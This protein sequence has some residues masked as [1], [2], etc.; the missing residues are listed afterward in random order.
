MDKT[1]KFEEQ[2]L[3]VLNLLHKK[4]SIRNTED[5]G[6]KTKDNTIKVSIY[7]RDLEEYVLSPDLIGEVVFELNKKEPDIKFINTFDND[8][9][10]IE[11]YIGNNPSIF[12]IEL[13][14]NFEDKYRKLRALYTRSKGGIKTVIYISSRHGIY[15]NKDKVLF[16]G[17]RGKRLKVVVHLEEGKV[18]GKTLADIYYKG[19][20]K[21]LSSEIKR[22]NDTFIDKLDLHDYLIVRLGTSGYD[23]NRD[24]YEVDFVDCK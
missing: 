7:P 13:P 12:D 14:L 18:S 17:I 6:I 3:L 1:D 11:Q 5:L 19:K 9:F 24:V 10:V 15:K 8:D 4:F 23:L 16:Y 2:I 22:I 21:G 20:I